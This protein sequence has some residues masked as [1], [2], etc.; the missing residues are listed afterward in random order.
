MGA[1]MILSESYDFPRGAVP[2]FLLF[3]S[4]RLHVH[5][6]SPDG[7]AKFWL[8]PTIALANYVG[9]D[10]RQLRVLQKLVEEREDDIR[11]AWTKH[12]R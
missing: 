11:N 9:F 2:L 12:F 3:A 8:E 10:E 6:T 4:E 5:I 1:T 7:E